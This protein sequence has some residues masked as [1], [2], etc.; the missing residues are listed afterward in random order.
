MKDPYA[1]LGVDRNAD[2]DVIRAKYDELHALYSEQRF[3]SGG[4]R[5]RA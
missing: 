1:V 3:K 4:Q 2:K 5:G